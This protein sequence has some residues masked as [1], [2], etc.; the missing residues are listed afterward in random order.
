MNFI[1]KA[2][3]LAALANEATIFN[4]P[5]LQGK[6]A[7]DIN[8]IH[9]TA[10]A[11]AAVSYLA[12]GVHYANSELSRRMIVNNLDIDDDYRK[13]AIA[14][15]ESAV[16]SNMRKISAAMEPVFSL[17][18][19]TATLAKLIATAVYYNDSI[20]EQSS[21]I[22]VFETYKPAPAVENSDSSLKI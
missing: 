19:P 1:E 18:L 8:D 21:I 2:K 4:L 20:N 6:I 13:M 14:I 10:G 5:Q 9:A 15:S 7:E 3:S 16:N 22:R 11:R 12:Y 17:G